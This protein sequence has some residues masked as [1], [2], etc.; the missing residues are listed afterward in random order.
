[1]LSIDSPVVSGQGGRIRST[2]R[3]VDES[4][5]RELW[6]EVNATDIFPVE[7]MDAYVV[8]CLLPAMMS[9]QDIEVK[10]P[11]SSKLFYNLT[12]Y[13]MPIIKEF[14][15]A[16]KVVAIRPDSLVAKT[17]GK[18]A[19]V[20][21]GFSGGVDS[22]SNYYD[23]SGS[24]A[25]KEY[26]ITH[27]IFNN[28]GSHGQLSVETDHAIFSKR[29]K[30]LEGF[31]QQESK[32]LI[33]VDSNL[34][35][36][37]GMDFML[38]NTLRNVAAALL[39]Q[40]IVSKFYYASSYS[41]RATQV[42]PCD[43]IAYLDPVILPLLGTE[44]LECIATGAQYNRID[45]TRHIA[46]LET[47][48]E[49]LDVCVTPMNAGAAVNCSRCWKCLRTQLTLSALGELRRYERIFDVDA[50]F[51]VENIFLLQV[52]RS[53]NPMV[54]EI[55]VFLRSVGYPIPRVITLLGLALPDK[56][57]KWLSVKL[58]GKCFSRPWACVVLNGF[59]LML[60][61]GGERRREVARVAEAA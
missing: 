18:A 29:T 39:M 2:S 24:R 6:F 15:P 47:S 8:G 23:H 34:D 54:R 40:N 28:V 11:L 9:G 26:L 14:L 3:I 59:F 27:F 33:T 41:F 48:T 52:V 50:Y 46:R 51:R 7:T 1:M 17:E 37:I 20:L 43:D 13:L 16:A 53:S 36:V 12:H 56:W 55:E 60:G 61:S 10:G 42:K 4:G 38:T 30:M 35:D 45:K 25:P 58:M 5:E 57:R 32:P 21:A 44:R 22:F 19:G 49:F 31:A